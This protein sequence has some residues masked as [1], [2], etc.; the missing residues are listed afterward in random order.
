M[1]LAGEG[2]T[3]VLGVGNDAAE[4][5]FEVQ[6]DGSGGLPAGQLVPNNFYSDPETRAVLHVRFDQPVSPRAENL[7]SQ[8]L[9][10]EYED[11]AGEW[12]LM[13]SLIVLEANCTGTGASV[14]ITP[15][16][17]LPQGRPMRVVVTPQ[18]E[19]L[20]GDRNA[21][22]L[23]KFAL[24][25][26]AAEVDGGGASVD[27]ADEF[28][29]LYL[30]EAF[31]DVEAPLPAPRAD[32]GPDGLAAAFD[33][34]GTGGP[35]GTLDIHVAPGTDVVFDTT[36]TLF[37]GGPGGLATHSQ[38][39]V[40]GRLDVR[41][42]FIPLG[43]SMRIQ[44]PNAATIYASG[45]VTIEGTLSVNGGNAKSVFTLN[46]P[47]QPEAGAAGQGGGG[48]GGTGSFLTT[49]VTP[50]GGNGEGGFGV[51]NLG[52]EGGESGYSDNA[53]AGGTQ[54]RAA[55]GGG[56]QLGHN[57]EVENTTGPELVLCPDQ[58]RI[59][60]DAES[61]FTGHDLALSSQGNH[62]PWGGHVG[63]SPFGI[64]EGIEN[65]F[66]GTKV[67][68]IGQ[69]DEQ[70]VVGELPSAIAGSGGG[71]G[72]DAT[73]TVGGVYPPLTLINVDQDKGAGGGGGG[74]SL[75]I[76]AL[77]D[78]TVGPQ[79]LISARGGHGNGGENT[80]GVN[81]VG[82]GSGGGSGGHLVL[83]TAGVIDFSAAS[84]QVN[85]PALD[86]KGGQGGEG[87]GGNGGA[88]QG[89]TG[90]NGDAKHI[91]FDNP[92]VGT[93]NGYLTGENGIDPACAVGANITRAAGGDGGP[94]LIQ[95][96]VGT[97]ATDIQY[98]SNVAN[99]RTIS[100]PV[101]HGYDPHNNVW[102]DQLL[103]VFGRL[104]SAQ[105]TWIALGE[106]AVDPNAP[107]PE[108]IAFLFEGTDPG[109]GLI[110]TTAGVVNA[111]APLL[112]AAALILDAGDT[113]NRTALMDATALVGG[114]DEIYL[115]NTGLLRNFRF[116]VAGD[117]FEVV[118]ASYDSGTSMLSVVVDSSIAG[119]A[120]AVELIPRYFGVTTAG[121]ED[122]LPDSASVTVSFELMG[123]KYASAPASEPDVVVS[124][125]MTDLAAAT[126]GINQSWYAIRF[127]RYRVEFDITNNIVD[128]DAG[129]PRP[130]L[131]FLRLP[132]RF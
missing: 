132:F 99:L 96:H 114:A 116:T 89:E 109:T 73:K 98:P 53:G 65:D 31:E 131:D 14:R 52:G 77:G 23:Q 42:L 20:V 63:P 39:A 47:T 17:V 100:S 76:L 108:S 125:F 66:L 21:S 35:A 25:T 40:N 33:F 12:I 36:Q 115:R 74:G 127:I 83:Q 34:D 117:P 88:S 119:L 37:F 104:S 110:E 2:T 111:Q 130:T 58:A 129:T 22:P 43:S 95:L 9:R 123:E 93:D 124:T 16:G 18:F 128:L 80:S 75:T 46:T 54:R 30:D 69:A 24:M 19:D 91:G 26:A 59:G 8:R 4:L 6:P 44:G 79:G 38:L 78:I 29:E 55:G 11:G 82:G 113:T 102:R 72:G 50:R 90:V 61:G 97:L 112:T 87:A 1:I 126:A 3:I 101:P 85:S 57:Q 56:G 94:G 120:G 67:M 32:W 106:P 45:T 68:N 81:R 27:T 103:P 105:S 5:F 71:A 48:D 84:T 122:A 92:P 121:V 51:P 62:I 60:L 10:L 70:L 64:L 49:Q 86:A 7:T 107:T 41:N 15:Q 13:N 28:L 118:V